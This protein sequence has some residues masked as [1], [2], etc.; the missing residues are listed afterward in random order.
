[1]VSSRKRS[2]AAKSKLR[3][4]PKALKALLEARSTESTKDNKSSIQDELTAAQ[5]TPRAPAVPKPAEPA[6]PK[7]A[8][9]AVP[10]PVK[11]VVPIFTITWKLTL[12]DTVVD[13]GSSISST[14]KYQQPKQKRKAI[15]LTSPDLSSDT[16]SSLSDSDSDVQRKRGKK[17]KKATITAKGLLDYKR[18]MRIDK[19]LAITS[20]KRRDKG[21]T[22]GYPPERIKAQLIMFREKAEQAQKRKKVKDEDDKKNN[23]RNTPLPQQPPTQAI[24]SMSPGVEFTQGLSQGMQMATM[25]SMNH[26]SSNMN[27]QFAPM[28]QWQQF[29]QWQQMQQMQQQQ[30]YPEPIL[31]ARSKIT[32]PKKNDPMPPSSPIRNDEDQGVLRSQYFGW[33]ITKN[34]SEKKAIRKAYLAVKREGFALRQI[35][36]FKKID[37]Q[38]LKI[39]YSL[40]E[41]LRADVKAWLRDR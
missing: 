23:S 21:V 25:A 22:V 40:G 7:P 39:P 3:S 4:N 17:Y 28:N 10:K 8:E 5:I 38:D 16:S 11:P 15:I 6:V 20:S 12:N 32:S 18:K 19:K 2:L 41:R 9:P 33:Q 29:L 35:H 1:M 30:Q 13:E 36:Q 26:L 34:R 37:W 27:N 24:S 14:F 31:P